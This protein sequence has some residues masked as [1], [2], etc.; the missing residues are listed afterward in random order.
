[1]PYKSA[2]VEIL[3]GTQR[4]QCTLCPV[5]DRLAAYNVFDG[6]GAIYAC[7]RHLTQAVARVATRKGG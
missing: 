1:M 7:G 4:P 2:S 5:S 6:N 3:E